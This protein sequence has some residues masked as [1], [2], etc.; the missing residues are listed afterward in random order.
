M[1]V[2]CKKCGAVVIVERNDFCPECGANLK[3][4]VIPESEKEVQ[5]YSALKRYYDGQKRELFIHLII[6]GGVLFLVV[7]RFILEKALY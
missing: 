2:V 3:D 4:A 1:K 6:L 7:L 5:T